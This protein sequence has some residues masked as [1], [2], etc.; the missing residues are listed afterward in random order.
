MYLIALIYEVHRQ[1]YILTVSSTVYNQTLF[2]LM[3][4]EYTVSTVSS[5]T[6]LN[7]YSII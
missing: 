5:K 4:I 7:E 1:H 2:S 3:D 6:T